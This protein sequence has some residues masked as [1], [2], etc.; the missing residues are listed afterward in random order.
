MP[1]KPSDNPLTITASHGSEFHKLI[2]SSVE[3][4]FLLPVCNQLAI[5]FI[6]WL[7]LLMCLR[8][9]VPIMCSLSTVVSVS[10]IQI[11][12]FATSRR[13]MLKPGGRGKMVEGNGIQSLHMEWEVSSTIAFY[14]GN[15]TPVLVGLKS[16]VTVFFI[17]MDF[18]SDCHLKQSDKNGHT[19]WHTQMDIVNMSI[20]VCLS[21]C[22]LN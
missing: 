11:T 2:L 1:L 17:V 21:I 15:R 5:N 3:T 8:K 12:N 14:H 9:N 18:L 13:N 7:Q 16:A 6:G 4:Y 20:C 19:Q 22:K 10:Q